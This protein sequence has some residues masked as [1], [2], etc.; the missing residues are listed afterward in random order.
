MRDGDETTWRPVEIAS[1]IQTDHIT[2]VGASFQGGSVA[3]VTTLQFKVCNPPQAL[4]SFCNSATSA[5]KAEGPAWGVEAA[6]PIGA[7]M[8]YS[9]QVMTLMYI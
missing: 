5:G 1:N 6:T 8:C 4:M 7:V 3:Q 9:R 2:R